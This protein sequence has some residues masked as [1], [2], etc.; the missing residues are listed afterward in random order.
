MTA[1][2]QAEARACS[3]WVV[4]GSSHRANPKT[5]PTNALL[6]KLATGGLD[7][8]T[9]VAPELRDGLEVRREASGQPDHF[10]VALRLTFQAA[11][12]GH[13]IEIGVDVK[14][15]AAWLDCSRDGR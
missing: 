10:G 7:G 5:L 6:V 14:A 3:I 12:G 15:S 2:V 11:V 13:A 9:V 8:G 4:A 1:A